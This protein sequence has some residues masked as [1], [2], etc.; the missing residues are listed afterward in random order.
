[1]SE[2]L[3]ADYGSDD[4]CTGC[5]AHLSEGHSPTCPFGDI[6]EEET[7]E[8][9]NRWHGSPDSARW[10]ADG[11]H[12]DPDEHVVGWEPRLHEGDTDDPR[13]WL[14]C[15]ASYN[16]GILHGGW[17]T[18]LA[19][20]EQI[21][22]DRDEVLASSP[23]PGAE[24]PFIADHENWG[25]LRIGEYESLE[26]LQAIAEGIDEHGEAFTAYLEEVADWSMD[27]PDQMRDRIMYFSDVYLGEFESVEAYVEHYFEDM[28][29]E[30]ELD[31]F[32]ERLGGLGQYIKFDVETYARDIDANGD[33]ITV[34][35]HGGIYV[36]RN[37]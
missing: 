33:I 32:R 30:H 16:A 21:C 22:A 23:E 35:S 10:K 18:M 31:E 37:Y 19:D 11:S 29:V 8:T 4:R 27:T 28:G 20:L 3:P 2:R 13:I 12:Q 36:F 7:Q 6:P 17:M 25:D 5:G 26:V 24:E 34:D 9:F 1:M 14:G 15:L